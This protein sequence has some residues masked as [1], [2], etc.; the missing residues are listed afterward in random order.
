MSYRASPEYRAIAD[1]YG[2]RRAERSGVMLINHIDEGV[3][4][5]KALHC[6]LPD[7]RGFHNYGPV[8][9]FCL[10]PLFQ[11][12][13]ELITVGAR[14]MQTRDIGRLPV[15]LAIEYR[16]KANAW[17]SDKVTKTEEQ[18]FPPV[19]GPIEF[20]DVYHLNGEPDA[21]P[22]AEVAAMLIADKV[23]NYKDFLTYHKG[24]HERSNEL[25]LYFKTWLKCLQV[26]EV[27][28]A[29]LCEAAKE[30]T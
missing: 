11:N 13:E 23:Q 27:L 15:M 24:T 1:H 6:Q 5:I 19:P 20:E 17:L 8:H 10:H 30:P 12:D 22:L 29:K 3:R 14:V 2:S 25:D 7:G 18:K 9:A 4:I 26:D 21:G 16:A 28:F